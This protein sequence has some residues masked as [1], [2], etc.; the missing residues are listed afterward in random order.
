[1]YVSYDFLEFDRIV[2]EL[3]PGKRVSI[4]PYSYAFEL[5][6]V[7]ADTEVFAELTTNSNVDFLWC[8][9]NYCNTN[10]E[11]SFADTFNIKDM[12][13]GAYFFNRSIPTAGLADGFAEFAPS[14]DSGLQM[15]RKIDGNSTLQL[16]FT[17]PVVGGFTNFQFILKGV[18]VYVYG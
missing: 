13:S 4:Q 6:T 2:S 5:P 7:A 14:P 1:M 18:H 11:T 15:P 17:T 8:D 3:Y 10:N 16:S 12:G 9:A